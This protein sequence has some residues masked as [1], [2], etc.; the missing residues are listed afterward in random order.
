MMNPVVAVGRRLTAAAVPR[1]WWRAVDTLHGG[2]L[3]V[4]RPMLT[5]ISPT[6]SVYL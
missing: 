2:G 5:W 1:T 4:E 6:I 3:Q